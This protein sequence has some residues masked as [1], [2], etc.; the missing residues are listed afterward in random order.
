MWF[1][2][3][4]ID[5]PCEYK[6]IWNRHKYLYDEY[7]KWCCR[8]LRLY[9]CPSVCLSVR[10]SICLSLNFNFVRTITRHK[11]QVESPY[12]RQTYIIGYSQLLL[13]NVGVIDLDLQCNFWL[14]ILGN[15]VCPH[16]NSSQ[17]WVSITKFA[18]KML[19]LK[20][21]GHSPL[22]FKV[23]LDVWTC[24]CNNLWSELETSNWHQICIGE[25]S[26]VIEN[27]SHWPWFSRSCGHFCSEFQVR[28]TSVL[29]TDQGRPMGFTRPKHASV[30]DDIIN[31]SF[32]FL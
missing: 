30:N 13:L 12:L 1:K 6:Q 16:D 5:H 29:Y 11:C 27:G 25:F 10:L 9:I 17:I 3:L 18:T 24:P 14:Q 7:S 8:C 19:V 15:S 22:I 32:A 31:N 20:N 21:G 28:S 4:L 26:A 23:I 2:V